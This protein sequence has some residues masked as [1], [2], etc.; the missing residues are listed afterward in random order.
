MNISLS[1]ELLSLLTGYE[2]TV[3]H[4]FSDTVNAEYQYRAVRPIF[5][6]LCILL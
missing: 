2:L 3:L 1:H 5:C 4:W 6:D